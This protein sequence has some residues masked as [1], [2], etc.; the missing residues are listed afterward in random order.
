M[1]HLL[2]YFMLPALIMVTSCTD[3]DLEIEQE[4]AIETSF[5]FGSYNGFCIGN[6]A[7][8]FLY[9]NG[10]VFR[11]DMDKFDLENLRFQST[12]EADLL[13]VGEKLLADLPKVL[14]ESTTETY[15][16][17]GCADQSTIFVQVTN[18]TDV[19]TW[20]LDSHIQKEWPQDLQDY[21]K[22]LVDELDKIIVY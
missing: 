9:E 12:A 3:S 4:E 5:I 2:F 7:H 14:E 18:D 13:A 22:V 19:K 11:D 6:C 8:L 20:Y 16:C 21:V 1:K 17:P 15:G 10:A